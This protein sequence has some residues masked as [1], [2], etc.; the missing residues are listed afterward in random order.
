MAI[1]RVII[2][3]LGE[4]ALY[5][6]RGLKS[7]RISVRAD[8]QI[9]V[10]LPIFAPYQAALAFVESRREWVL[11]HRPAAVQL[12]EQ[13][14]AIGKQH[15]LLFTGS[16]SKKTASSRITQST[17]LVS[18]PAAVPSDDP[19]V[20]KVAVTAAIRA[21]RHEAEDLLPGRVADIAAR[22]GFQ[23]KS[24]VVKKLKGRWG[25]CDQDHN[26]VLNL[27]LMQ[28]PWELVDYVILHELVHTEH[29]HHGPDFWTSFLGHESAAKQL[30][31]QIRSYQP[32]LLFRPSE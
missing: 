20:Q 18:H 12:L 16:F 4:V 1:K 23:Y 28:L 2:D 14:Q 10:S 8:G 25:S 13:A 27:Y 17:I 6:R 21:L 24:V 29:L 11:A 26:N 31:K 9:R 30:R 7:I 19:T 3:G 22:T 15:R 5:K 32:N